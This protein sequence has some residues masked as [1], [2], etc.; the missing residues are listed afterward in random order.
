MPVQARSR[1]PFTAAI[2]GRWLPAPTLIEGLWLPGAALP[3]APPSYPGT[4]TDIPRARSSGNTLN[5]GQFYRFFF[6]PAPGACGA[7]HHPP[8]PPAA[9]PT[10]SYSAPPVIIPCFAKY[11]SGSFIIAFNMPI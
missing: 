10:P 7:I 9:P 5:R 11:A 2:D 4:A 1:L 6:A 8:A 3:A